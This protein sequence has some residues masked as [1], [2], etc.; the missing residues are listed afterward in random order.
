M[1]G[2]VWPFRRCAAS[3]TASSR[4]GSKLGEK[5]PLAPF[6][7]LEMSPEGSFEPS[8]GSRLKSELDDGDFDVASGPSVAVFA[9]SV[10]LEA[11]PSIADSGFLRGSEAPES[12]SD[13]GDPVVSAGSASVVVGFAVSSALSASEDGD[14]DNEL[15]S[16]TPVDRPGK[17]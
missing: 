1:W 17:A 14:E 7:K 9:P 12:L 16:R 15:A 6:R 13:A 2:V 3:W 11:P 5:R 10:T 4:S 8:V